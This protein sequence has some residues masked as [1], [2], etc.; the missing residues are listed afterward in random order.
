MTDH[1]ADAGNY[2]MSQNDSFV[3]APTYGSPIRSPLDDAPSPSPAIVQFSDMRSP[4]DDILDA[5][6]L[7]NKAWSPSNKQN[8]DEDEDD[9][10]DDEESDGES[11]CMF[12]CDILK[13]FFACLKPL[14]CAELV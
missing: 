6:A 1:S 4:T 8:D 12:L 13:I 9:D 14:V 7:L 10:D 5:K 11:M 2:E 3:A